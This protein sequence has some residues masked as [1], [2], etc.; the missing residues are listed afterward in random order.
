MLDDLKGCYVNDMLM[1]CRVSCMLDDLKGCY[2]NDMLM[3]CRVSCMLDDLKGSPTEPVSFRTQCCEPDPP[4]P[5]K[6]SSK[7]K[8]SLQLKWSVSNSHVVH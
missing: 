6:L 8:T 3:L 4:Q 5:A 7:T 2:V 1:L